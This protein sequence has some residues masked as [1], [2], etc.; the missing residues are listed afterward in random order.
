[1]VLISAENVIMGR[2]RGRWCTVWSARVLTMHHAL[3]I[4]RPIVAL[5][6][7]KLELVYLLGTGLKLVYS[8]T[9]VNAAAGHDR[10]IC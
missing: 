3:S 6:G 10:V 8:Q 4:I 5:G 9:L 7:A 2:L 1:M